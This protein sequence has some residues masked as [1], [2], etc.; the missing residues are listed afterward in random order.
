[1]IVSD[2]RRRR[3]LKG[4]AAPV[5]ACD[6][7]RLQAL[8]LLQSDMTLMAEGGLAR[9]SRCQGSGGSVIT[10][11]PHHRRRQVCGWE[12]RR[13]LLAAAAFNL[14]T[15]IRAHTGAAH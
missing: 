3:V 11:A 4:E 6:L 14:D 1:M 10:P 15:Y 12:G 2:R 13:R 7:A 5:K 9:D 8:Q